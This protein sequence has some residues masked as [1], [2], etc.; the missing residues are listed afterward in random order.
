[1]SN[2]T[3]EKMEW[4]I[5]E[6]MVSRDEILTFKQFERERIHKS[7]AI[8]KGVITQCSIL[9][10]PNIILID[11]F[12]QGLNLKTK[13]LVGNVIQFGLANQQ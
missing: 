1:M 6:V 12:Y 11:Y 4:P 13:R 2:L 10:F 7:R 3:Y 8:F 5:V 9:E